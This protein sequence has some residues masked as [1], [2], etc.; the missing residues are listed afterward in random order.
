VSSGFA[1]A[2]YFRKAV[3]DLSLVF[4]PPRNEA[5]EPHF[6]LFLEQKW[7]EERK[8]L[9]GLE[10]AGI[11]A[12]QID[13]IRLALFLFAVGLTTYGRLDVVPF[14]L[15]NVPSVGNLARL[16]QVAKAV[17]PLPENF[18]HSRD[19]GAI[20][21]WVEAHQETLEWDSEAEKFGWKAKCA[22]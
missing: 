6:L 20:A 4:D 15:R 18:V 14:M 3:R 5:W 7:Q 1:P 10:N 12:R 22:T 17:L 16:A 2:E 8:R 21:D 19:W 13:D 11:P 9:M